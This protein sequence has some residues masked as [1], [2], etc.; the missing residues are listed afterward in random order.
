M[1]LYRKE[2]DK[3]NELRLDARRVQGIGVAMKSQLIAVDDVLQNNP[4]F[5][6]EV[7]AE[8]TD[9]IQRKLMAAMFMKGVIAR[10]SREAAILDE[11]LVPV[12]KRK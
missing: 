1:N 11:V 8:Y 5:E 6:E 7:P 3:L 9:P 4:A 2:F 12:S 10:A